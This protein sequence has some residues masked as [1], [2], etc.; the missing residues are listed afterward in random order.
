[1]RYDSNKSVN[2]TEGGANGETFGE[3]SAR[4]AAFCDE[5]VQS[6]LSDRIV[7]IAHAGTIDAA[8]RWPVGLTPASPWQHEFDLANGSITELEFWPQGRVPGGAPRYAVLRCVG[9]VAHLGDL[10][11]DL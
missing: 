9:D 2:T 8:I 4:V 5:I 11:S 10:I 7:V 1:M 6:H 3:F